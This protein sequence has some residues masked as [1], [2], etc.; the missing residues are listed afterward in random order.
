V[1]GRTWPD[2]ASMEKAKQYG[3]NEVRDTCQSYFE[4]F[5]ELKK[6]KVIP[7]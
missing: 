5:D 6:M 1:T 2:Y 3:W 4:V 7:K